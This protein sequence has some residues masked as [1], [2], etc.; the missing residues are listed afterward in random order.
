[1]ETILQKTGVMYCRVSSAEQVAGTS[2]EMQQRTCREWAE[3]ENIKIVHTPFIEEGESAKTANRTEFQKALAFCAAKKPKVDFFIVHKLDRFARSQEDHAVTQA[4]LKKHGTRL[5]SVTEQIDETPVGKA[6]EGMLSVFAEFDNNVRASRSKSGMVERLKQGV[7]VWAAPI[8]YKRLTQGGNL[9]ADE[10]RAPYV[11]LAF[12]EWA[13]GTYSLRSLSDFLY[14]RGFRTHK[15]GKLRSQQIHNLLHNPL[16]VGIMRMGDIEFQGSFSSIVDEELYFK[17]QSRIRRKFSPSNPVSINPHFPLR[18]FA[19]C[20]ECKTGLTGSFSTGRKKVRYPYYHHH[21]QNCPLATSLSKVVVEQSF[22][23]LLEEVSP[24]HKGYEKAFKAIVMD[25]WQANYKKLDAENSLLRKEI[26]ALEN[27]RQRIFD[28]HRSGTYSDGEF[29]EQK[30]YIN[31]LL[32]QKKQL[33]EEKRIEEFNMETALSY[34]FEFVRDSGDTWNSFNEEPDYRL[35][36][37]KMIFPE[38][39]TFDGKKFDTTKMSIVYEL[40]QT[41]GTD[42]QNLVRPPGLEPGTLSLRGICSTN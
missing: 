23:E 21:K 5:R 39:V 36:F 14:E 32:Q 22:T 1:M 11:R 28:L 3:R 9:V 19:V 6:M 26:I 18:R 16:Y 12:E 27:E 31:Q 40:N 15:N 42:L 24:K 33:S 8:G 25:R 20:T 38:K 7:W 4:F 37:Q 29:V 30:D 35:R 41:T 2:L 34:C 17:C 13:K 10:E